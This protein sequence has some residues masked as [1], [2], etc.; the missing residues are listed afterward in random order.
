MPSRSRSRSYTVTAPFTTLI[1]GI[2]IN[3][4]IATCI[5]G[6]LYL[7]ILIS[8]LAFSG[9]KW[10]RQKVWF[11]TGCLAALC[12]TLFMMGININYTRFRF[13]KLSLS[14]S[15]VYSGSAAIM[16][17]QLTHSLLFGICEEPVK[18]NEIY[19]IV[20]M[21]QQAGNGTTDAVLDPDDLYPYKAPEIVTVFKRGHV[22][23]IV[24]WVMAVPAAAFQIVA[25]YYYG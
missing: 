24:C 6:G 23:A 16:V 2:P 21:P 22:G 8:L 1:Y 14:A 9:C 13:T 19:S 4:F 7:I 18:R 12:A 25:H 3:T 10:T 17:W 20:S 15:L 11:F 5:S